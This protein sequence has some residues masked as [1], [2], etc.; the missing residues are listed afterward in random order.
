MENDFLEVKIAIASVEITVVNVEIQTLGW[1]SSFWRENPNFRIWNRFGHA[2]DR[3]FRL[4]NKE[5]LNNER[6]ATQKIW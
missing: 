2:F 1:K 4:E 3:E 5:K 6:L